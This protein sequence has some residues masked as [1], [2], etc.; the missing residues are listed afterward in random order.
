MHSAVD[1]QA[2]SDRRAA[3]REL[4]QP[5]PRNKGITLTGFLTRVALLY[6]AIAYFLVCPNDASRDRAVCRQID[7]FSSRIRSY[8]PTF[9]P[10]YRT[11]QRKVD[12]YVRRT[13][14]IAQ[15]YVNKA[16]PYYSRADKVVTPRI[17]QAYQFYLK[18]VYPRMVNT[19]KSVRSKTRP[20]ALKV[21][22]EYKKTLAPSVDWYSK[23]LNKWYTKRVEPSLVRVLEVARQYFGTISN[24]LSPVYTQG[25]PLVRHHY[26]NN[27][28]PFSRST[29]S[30]TRK[31][32][33][34]HVH[35]QLATASSYVHKIYLN[36][37]SPSLYRFWSKFI[38]P[39]LDKIRERIFEFKAKE[40]RVAAMKKIEKVSD[41][42]AHQHG[43]EDFEGTFPFSTPSNANL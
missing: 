6:L 33:V 29:Y 17:K 18:R 43:E 30:A 37:V 2:E 19:V 4:R 8:E 42:I 35:P 39:Q 3:R 34:S 41:E 23:S 24:S 20:F 7:S 25:V 16:K 10:Y 11:A 38:A 9:R 12:P 27:L 28:V 36:K 22:R 40:A 21:E 13:K 26:R 5:R 14:K 32:Y 31:T 15:P 1:Q